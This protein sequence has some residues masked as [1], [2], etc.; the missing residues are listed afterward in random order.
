MK[1]T[2]F[3]IYQNQNKNDRQGGIIK[4]ILIFVIF[5]LILSYFNIDLRSVIQSPQTQQNIGYA[6]T[7]AL[8]VWGI[9]LK[10]LWDNYLSKPVLYLW[11]N[12]FIEILWKS[13][14]QGLSALQAGHFN[15]ASSTP[16][17][18]SI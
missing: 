17:V 2:L 16:S 8:K 13:F 12:I 5:I 15:S 1:A 9:A 6:K 4:L 3:M 7:F 11:Q 14:T 10:P 18:P